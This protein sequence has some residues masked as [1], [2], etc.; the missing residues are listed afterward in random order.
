MIPCAS[1]RRRG[2]TLLELLTVIATIATLAALLLPVLGKAKTKAQGTKCMSNLRQLGI[3]WELY[4]SENGGWLV[5]SYPANNTNAWVLGDMTVAAEATNLELLRRGKLFPYNPSVEIYHCPGDQ[6]ARVNGQVFASVRSYS[7]NGFMGARDPNLGPI[8]AMA[9]NYVP[10]YAKESDLPRPA[11]LWVL[12]DEDERSINDGFFMADP[13][14]NVWY[15]FP[16]I[17][18]P[19]HHFSY[20]LAFGDG[21]ADVWRLSDPKT[22]KV[23]SSR[24]EQPGNQ[25][26]ARLAAATAT[27]KYS[28][29]TPE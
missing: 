20:A 29:Y 25:D 8:P 14:G 4:A 17:S 3:A 26:L 10:F 7:M 28:T 24:L 6:G 15:D 9:V 22:L 19:R 1:A 5:E 23:Q 11:G 16:A 18:A 21:H 2:F 27:P 13:T 12:L